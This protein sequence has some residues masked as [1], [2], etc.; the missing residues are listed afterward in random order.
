MKDSISFRTLGTML[1]CSRNAVPNLESLKSWID[2]TA[3][4]GYNTLYLY[5]EDTYEIPDEPFFGYLRGRYSQEELREVDNYAEKRG[6]TIIPHIQVLAHLLQLRRWPHYRRHFDINDI[7]LVGDEFVYTLIDK[8][9]ASI[10]DCFRCK[11][12]HIGMDEAHK[13]GRGKYFDLHGTSNQLDIMLEHLQRVCEIGQ[14]YGFRFQIWSD[15]F[16]RLVSGGKYYNADAVFDD[17]VKSMIPDNVELV[18]WDYYSDDKPH[19]DAMIDAHRR[20]SDYVCFAGGFWS[21]TGFSPH[22]EFSIS[23]TKAALESCREHNVQDVIFTI[24]GDDGAECSPYSLLP[25]LFY[26]AQLARGCTDDSIIREK[27]ADRF[28]LA[29]DDFVKLDLPKLPCI[30]EAERYVPKQL[31]Y[32]DCFFGFQDSTIGCGV[33]KKYAQC[34][35]ELE[36]LSSHYQWGYLFETLAAY[37]RVLEIKSELGIH[38]REIYSLGDPKALRSLIGDYHELETRLERF[39][40]AFQ[41]Q[42]FRENK[43][44]GFD[45]HDIRLGGLMRRVKSCRLRLEQ[46]EAGKIDRIEELEDKIIELPFSLNYLGW[47]DVVTTNV[48]P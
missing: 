25:S 43:P 14:K 9:F 2:L 47:S 10:A 41:H 27:F 7:L 35:V 48:F 32:N 26:A 42:W 11:T 17:E 23:A 6:M 22:N 34:A 29:F 39:Y 28:G 19:Y 38:T 5:M 13:I 36:R 21:W 8:M 31:L 18:Y 33:G 20:L 3:E 1:D 15:M 16:F 12:V 4:M 46:Y 45:V 37:C 30:S 40:M 44:H 24:W